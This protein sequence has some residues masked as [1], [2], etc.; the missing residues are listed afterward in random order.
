MTDTFSR[1]GIALGLGLLVGLQRERT[2]AKLA[3]FRTFEQPVTDEQIAL[4]REKAMESRK[5][6]KPERS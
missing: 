2:D 1:L 4:V 6:W 5:V 3:G